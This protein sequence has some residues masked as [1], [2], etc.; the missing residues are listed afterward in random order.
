MPCTQIPFWIKR[1]V[2]FMSDINDSPIFF[3]SMP[4]SNIFIDYSDNEDMTKL[5]PKLGLTRKRA[6][7]CIDHPNSFKYFDPRYKMGIYCKLPFISFTH[8]IRSN[9]YQL[10]SS[11]KI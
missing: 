3:F 5:H 6:C 10:R 7:Q 2:K 8:P 11:S 9:K 4:W 1:D